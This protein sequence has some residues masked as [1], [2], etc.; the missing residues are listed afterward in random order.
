MTTTII[1]YEIFF[2]IYVYRRLQ[3]SYFKEHR[4]LLERTFERTKHVS[5]SE[6]SDADE[7]IRYELQQLGFLDRLAYA[8]YK[9]K[10]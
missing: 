6:L 3:W 4:P 1:L 8:N 9:A 5:A 7:A 2:A 10:E